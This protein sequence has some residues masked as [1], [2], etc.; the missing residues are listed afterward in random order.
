LYRYVE[1]TSGN[2]YSVVDLSAGYKILN[3][4]F[5]IFVNNLFNKQYFENTFVPMPKGNILFGMKY[6][7]K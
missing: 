7:F 3:F 4:E 6:L 1:R 5:T 2:S